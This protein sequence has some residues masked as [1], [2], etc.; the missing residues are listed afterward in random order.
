MTESETFNLVDCPECSEFQVKI[1]R[2][3]SYT[4]WGRIDS[5]TGIDQRAE[6][7][8]L[9]RNVRFYG[10]MNAEECQYAFTRES[11]G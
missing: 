6:V 5:R 2:T 3:P 1:D 11:L 7:G 9:S 4:H 8:I 10:E